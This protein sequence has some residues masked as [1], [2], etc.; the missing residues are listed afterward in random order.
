MKFPSP[1]TEATFVR[2]YKR[3]FA[4]FQLPDGSVVTAHCA[5]PGSMNTCLVPGAKSWLSRSV[6][7]RRKLA[8]T[9]EV[10]ECGGTRVFVNPV[11]ANDV[12]LAGI[13]S[14]VVAELC[15]YSVVRREVA[16]SERTRIDFVLSGPAR[17][18]YVEVKNVTMA[19]EPG[20]AAFPDSV[21]VR[22]TRHLRELQALV[23]Q[24]QRAI[25]FFCVA[26][27]DAREVRPAD[28]VDPVYG[29]ALREA[30]A[31][32]VEVLAYRCGITATGVELVQQLPVVLPSLLA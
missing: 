1:I 29:R 4:D 28:G 14:G 15:D 12:V 7:P 27:E 20:Q 19:L 5:N 13:R 26:R 18:C 2:R 9:W 10:V 22:G 31:R 6:N 25:L 16:I 23:E 30:V 8:Y 11:R 24:G 17:T 3:F 21:T 32:G